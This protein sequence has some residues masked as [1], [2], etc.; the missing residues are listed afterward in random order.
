MLKY[1][2][3]RIL[4]LI[5]VMLGVIVIV[6]VL[7]AVTPGDPIDQI[8]GADATEEQREA[9]REELGLNDPLIVQ[10]GN[11]LWGI[12]TRGDLGTSY[13]S[14][15]PVL[16]ELLTRFPVT[17]ILALGSV[18]LGILLGI[19]LGVISA[20]KQYS[21]ADSSILVVSMAAVSMPSF[22]LALLCILLFAVKLNW[23]PASGIESP[24]GWIL[25]ICVVGLNTMSGITRITR[26]SMLEVIRQDYVRTARAKGQK[27]RVIVVHHAL[28]SALIPIIANIGNQ[29]GVQLGGALTIEA[30]FGLPGIGQY[31]VSAIGARNFPAVQGGVIILA[32]TFTIVNLLVDLAYTVVDPRMK[33]EFSSSK[34]KRKVMLQAEEGAVNG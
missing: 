1:V 14:N 17:I 4:M 9:K 22:W 6:F 20:T 12:I 21:W 31:V 25:P 29:I 30:V 24:L 23:L 32:F 3:K 15:Q 16:T 2:I 8:L 33:A 28:R 18:L 26:S 19:P 27:E 11:Y 13:K 5:P 34:P 10:F 7:K